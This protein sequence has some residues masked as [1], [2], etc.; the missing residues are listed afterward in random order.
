MVTWRRIALSDPHR[1]VHPGERL[2]VGRYLGDPS[3]DGSALGVGRVLAQPNVAVMATKLKDRTV[4]KSMAMPTVSG[5]MEVASFQIPKNCCSSS[6]R[7]S[8]SSCTR[9]PSSSFRQAAGTSS[10]TRPWT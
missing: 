7:T 8:G 3:D 6:A 1:L 4:G 5:S 10:R 9:M 2:V